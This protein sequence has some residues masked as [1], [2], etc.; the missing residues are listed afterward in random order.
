MNLLDDLELPDDFFHDSLRD[1]I[2]NEKQLVYI[3]PQEIISES[4]EAGYD[5]VNVSPIGFMDLVNDKIVFGYKDY[6]NP[7]YTIVNDM[8]P[9][10]EVFGWTEKFFSNVV[11]PFP[12]VSIASPIIPPSRYEKYPDFAVVDQVMI[13]AGY[14]ILDPT[15]GQLAMYPAHCDNVERVYETY[16]LSPS[17]LKRL[18]SVCLAQYVISCEIKTSFRVRFKNQDDNDYVSSHSNGMLAS[19]EM[20]GD[21]YLDYCYR[22]VNGLSEFLD[23]MKKNKKIVVYSKVVYAVVV[24]VDVHALEEFSKDLALVDILPDKRSRKE[25]RKL[26]FVKYFSRQF[27]GEYKASRNLIVG[28][29]F[30]PYSPYAASDMIS[31]IMEPEGVKYTKRWKERE[32]RGFFRYDEKR[33]HSDVWFPELFSQEAKYNKALMSVDLV[34]NSYRG[35]ERDFFKKKLKLSFL[36]VPLLLILFW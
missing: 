1:M 21:K 36:T 11:K 28:F 32:V 25:S 27:R 10:H 3:D 14:R 19:G 7:R 24:Y 35:V 30:N 26:G 31:V 12:V 17:K 33:Y 13:A 15:L 16:T 29:D 23:K 4:V 22:E 18:E 8:Q 20:V 5:P 34:A 6:Q 9:A 2:D